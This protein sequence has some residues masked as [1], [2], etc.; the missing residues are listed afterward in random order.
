MTDASAELAAIVRAFD[1]SVTLEDAHTPPA[2]WYVNDAFAALERERVFARGWTYAGPAEALAEPGDF[3]TGEVAGEPWVVVRQSDGGLKGMF[4]VCRHHAAAVVSGQ[5]NASELVCPYHGWRYA[6]DGELKKAPELGGARGFKKENYGLVPLR[7]QQV[8][9][10]LFVSLA[11]APRDLDADV[12]PVLAALEG[13][14]MDGLVYSARRTWDLECNWKVFVDNYLDGGYHVGHLHKDLSEGLA[15]D[16][17][18]TV[19]HPH[20]S[21]QSCGGTGSERVGSEAV[22]AFMHPAFMI[23]RY[24]PVLDINA[25]VPLGTHRCRVIFDFWFDAAVAKD[26]AFVE[27]AIRES[28]QVQ[29]EDIGICHDV[30]RGLRS[31]AYTAGRYSV[32]R[33]GPMFHFH[34]LLAADVSGEA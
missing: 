27:K 12:A 33:E 20:S 28:E 11:D 25:V 22:Y 30:Q 17:Y 23:N 8:G 24:G 19:I 32:S 16:S 21:V 29:D 6:L 14:G 3:V 10:F 1:A 2:S 26:A 31:R 5:G 4:N 7:A 18:R 13:L 15:L 34:Q 9:P